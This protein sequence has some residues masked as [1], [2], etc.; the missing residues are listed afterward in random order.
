MHFLKFQSISALLEALGRGELFI[1]HHPH[2]FEDLMMTWDMDD[3]A[4]QAG[5]PI[6]RLIDIRD[7][8][9]E[10]P[11]PSELIGLARATGIKFE[12][13]KTITNKG[14]RQSNGC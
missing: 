11:D 9:G 14:T 6:E 3:L 2:T 13:L 8:K 12:M 5:I 7:G 4:E 10:Q 1:S